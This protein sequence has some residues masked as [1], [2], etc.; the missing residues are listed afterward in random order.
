MIVDSSA[1]VSLLLREHGW[2]RIVAA[3]TTRSR[4]AIGAPTLTETAI[5]LHAKGVLPSLLPATLLR[6]GMEVVPYTERHA[7]VA[8]DAYATY[9]RGRHPASLNFGDCMT[10]A[11]ARL[12]Q[13]PLLFVGNDFALTDIEPALTA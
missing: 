8:A 2:Q 4:V 1:I 13:A 3:L 7:L 6:T 5:V 10:Y 12:A 11:V 9:G